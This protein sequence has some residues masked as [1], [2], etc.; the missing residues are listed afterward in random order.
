MK[1]LGVINKLLLLF[2][3]AI[4]SSSII[5][6]SV[7]Y[8]LSKNILDSNVQLTSSQ[9]LNESAN[10]LTIYLKSL[11]Q[12]VD[13]LTRKNEL[14]HLEGPDIVE[15]NLASTYDSLIAALKTTPGAMQG[16]YI[17]VN[18]RLV[19]ILPY[20]KDGKTKY[21]RVL[22]ENIDLHNEPWY[23]EALKN[24]NRL[25]VYAGYTEP[26]FSE[27]LGTEIITVS[28]CIKSKE[29]LVGVVAIDIALSSITEFVNNIKLLN[30]GSVFLIN[31]EGEV[32]V[33][34]NNDAL[35]L[36]SFSTLPIWENLNTTEP[37]SL[38]DNLN[39]EDYYITSLTDGITNWK[40]VGL[41]NEREITDD[42]STLSTCTLL[43]TL[44]ALAVSLL[45][46]LFSMRTFKSKFKTLGDNL[47][48]IAQGDFTQRPVIPGHDEFHKLSENIQQMTKSI[49]ALI[50][51]VGETAAILFTTSNQINAITVQTQDTSSNVKTATDE[52][53]L[54]TAQQASSMQDISIQVDA[55]GRQL[56]ETK[57][58]TANVKNMTSETQSLSSTGLNM[59]QDL[60]ETSAHSN[61]IAISS[62]AFFKDMT[63]SINK[64][65]FISNAIIEITNQTSLL[66]LNASIEAARAGESGNGFAV[67]AEEIRKL[68]EASKKST[69]EIK[70]IV[71]EINA[72]SMQA[73]TA[74][75]ESQTL[76][77]EQS[78][79]IASTEDV[80]KNI[81]TSVNNLVK[82]IY[83]VD[84]LNTHMVQSKNLVLQNMD[85]IAAISEQTASSSQEVTASTEEVA[86]TMNRLS[87]ETQHLIHAADQLSNNLKLFKF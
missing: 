51:N 9:T 4:V 50:G 76:L 53:S 27:S 16:Y 13:L 19:N 29:E 39:G 59:L 63:E 60:G 78:D 6:S 46:I 77:L 44:G 36:T 62:Y 26:Y 87:D 74:L 35:S 8:A 83:A 42:L 15:E 58:Y 33:A 49:S 22:T 57:N 84:E 45:Y 72:K 14:K 32:L 73:S 24:E 71:D 34:P 11:S 28:Q 82:D 5:I 20:E 31:N 12:Q 65:N 3:V 25:G 48:A 54:G 41:I 75:E 10:A 17:T 64:I 30:T 18:N 61:K 52:I 56:E 66:S 2:C 47:S 81:I 68:S 43:V 79:A 67:V 86:T 80:F 23:I 85:E 21:E 70:N 69:D 40:L 38:K 7:T 37:V 1:K 55:L